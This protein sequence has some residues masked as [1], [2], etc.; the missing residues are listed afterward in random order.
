MLSGDPLDIQRRETTVTRGT[1]RWR[2]AVRRKRRV[3]AISG[4]ARQAVSGPANP[5]I[6]AR[7]DSECLNLA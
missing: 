1:A 5:K 7:V 2:A 3:S 4:L 6:G